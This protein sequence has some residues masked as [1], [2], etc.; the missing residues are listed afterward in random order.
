MVIENVFSALSSPNTSQLFILLFNSLKELFLA[1]A[2]TSCV[3]QQAMIDFLCFFFFFYRVGHEVLK[4]F[5]RSS[6]WA[7]PVFFSPSL[8]V[9]SWRFSLLLSEVTL[10]LHSSTFRETVSVGSEVFFVSE[11]ISK[12]LT[13][14][15]TVQDMSIDVLCELACTEGENKLS[16]EHHCL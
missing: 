16:N 13:G 12:V 14:Q 10:G 4:L 2:H 15:D 3:S 1:W 9:C 11:S 6:C 8:W 5:L 7:L